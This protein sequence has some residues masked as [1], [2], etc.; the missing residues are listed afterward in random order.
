MTKVG[1]TELDEFQVVQVQPL[2][3][4]SSVESVVV[5]ISNKPRP[6]MP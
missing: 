1:Q 5:L 2:V 3:D 4:F 6:E